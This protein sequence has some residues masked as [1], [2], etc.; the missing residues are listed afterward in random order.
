MTKITHWRTHSGWAVRDRMMG[1]GSKHMIG[2]RE[3][4]IAIK[5]NLWGMRVSVEEEEKRPVKCPPA[6]YRI[7]WP[8]NKS[9]TRYARRANSYDCLRL[10]GRAARVIRDLERIG[11][12]NGSREHEGIERGCHE[13]SSHYQWGTSEQPD[14][15]RSSNEMG[16]AKWAIFSIR[17]SDRMPTVGSG[18]ETIE[19]QNRVGRR[20][21]EAGSLE[22]CEERKINEEW[23]QKRAAYA[24][25]T[26]EAPT[27][28]LVP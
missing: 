1:N 18:T 23:T 2:E 27:R 8:Q 9:R 11:E 22:R 26:E 19:N 15:Q 3:R 12:N 5:D 21:A 17:A 20:R 4:A 10:N 6:K 7:Q 14:V 25:G 13:P 24:T 28:Y 16:D